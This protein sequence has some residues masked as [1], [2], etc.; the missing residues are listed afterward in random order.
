MTTTNQKIVEAASGIS[1]IMG[2]VIS[3]LQKEKENLLST[4]QYIALE[5]K[6][7]KNENIKLKEIAMK[8][9]IYKITNCAEDFK[10]K[11]DKY[12]DELKFYIDK[13]EN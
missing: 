4:N 7:L 9:E 8:F 6:R 10:D 5:N 1:I 12:K 2:K 11:C 3:K 13:V